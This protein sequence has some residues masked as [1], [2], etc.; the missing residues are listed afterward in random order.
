MSDVFANVG[1]L[2]LTACFFHPMLPL[3]IPLAFCGFTL[4]YW[5]YKFNLLRKVER[6]DELG[7]LLPMFFANLIPWIAF[8]WALSLSLFYRTIYETAYSSTSFHKRQ[9]AL[10]LTLGI[11]V[12][13]ILLPFRS[14]VKKFYN[15]EFDGIG[16]KWYEDM[17][18]KFLTD[19]DRENPITKKAGIIKYLKK[20][21]SIETDHQRKEELL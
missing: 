10:W 6:P 19:Y 5:V 21:A 20:L 1:N 12:L 18:A 8:F 14:I 9:V 11:T 15:K 16:A 7:S 3:S 17:I 4:S 2:L 13:Y